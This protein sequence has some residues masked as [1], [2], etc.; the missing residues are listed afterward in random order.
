[1]AERS[2]FI[3]K[4]LVVSLPTKQGGGG[5]TFIPSDEGGDLPWWISPVAAVLAKGRLVEVVRATVKDALENGH[6]L[7]PIAAAFEGDPDGN[8]AI[9]HAIRE[10]GGAVVAGAVVAGGGGGGVA[11]PDPNCGG[12]SLET[13]PTPITPIVHRGLEVHRVSDLPRMRRQL[14]I[15]VERL[16]ELS[17]R[18]APQD[19]EVEDVAGALR[20]AQA[21][22]G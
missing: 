14:E 10:I 19:R 11:M 17:G 4:D 12:T 1:M 21:G 20:D 2:E 8:P 5:G 9:R 16:G 15:A 7:T 3:I 22:L 18:L 13:I 6:D